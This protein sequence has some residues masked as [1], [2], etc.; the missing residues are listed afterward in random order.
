MLLLLLLALRSI[1]AVSFKLLNHS[2]GDLRNEFRR[3]KVRIIVVDWT[4]NGGG[5]I[6]PDMAVRWIPRRSRRCVLIRW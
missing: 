4:I 5:D 2:R 3:Q 1:Q 6:I